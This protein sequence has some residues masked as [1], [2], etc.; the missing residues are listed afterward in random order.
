MQTIKIFKFTLLVA[1]FALLSACGNSDVEVSASFSSTQKIEQG[2]TVYF[3]ENVVGEVA[4][5]EQ[6]ESGT[7]VSLTIEEKAA[8]KISTNAA[9]VVNRIKPGAPL[10]IHVSGVPSETYLQDGQKIEGLNSMFDLVAWS[11]GDALQAGTGEIVGYVDSFQTYLEGEQFQQDKAIVEEGVK[12]MADAATEAIKTVEQDLQA[13]MSEMS[14][15]EEELAQAIRELGD[16][17]SPLAKE[18]AKGGTDL[19]F[20]LEKF[21]QGLDSASTEDRESGEKLIEAL[22]AAIEK[23][24]QS[25]EEGVQESQDNAE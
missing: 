23:L 3:E 10:E 4:S 24:D 8:S 25:A 17:M 2:T 22:S 21:A 1:V 12:Q 15:T 14:I 19:M 5:V 9:V 11:V 18:M 20:E 13:A 16:E 7:F 6:M